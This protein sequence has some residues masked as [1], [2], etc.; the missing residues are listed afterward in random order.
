MLRSK[1]AMNIFARLTPASA[2]AERW[3]QLKLLDKW[4]PLKTGP[5]V[6]KLITLVTRGRRP[7]NCH[8]ARPVMVDA[9]Q[10]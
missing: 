9:I 7:S 10:R 5:P 4:L 1:S 8:L 2:R 3:P 6:T